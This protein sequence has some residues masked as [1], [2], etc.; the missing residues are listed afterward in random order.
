M[1]TRETLLNALHVALA[2]CAG[3]RVYRSRKEQLPTVPAIVIRP[4]SEEDNG[5]M[6]GVTDTVL[7]VAI[8]IYAR[9]DIPDK[10]ADATLSAAYA[11]I[12]AARD[13]G[14]GSD[15]QLMPGRTVTW[16]VDGYDD[17]DVTLSLSYLYRT[18]LGAM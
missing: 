14:M 3:G 17:A 8:D 18:A 9:G 4:E 2:G 6:L 12:I 11:A 5:E 7:V 1:S 13:L 15:V 10:A 16:N